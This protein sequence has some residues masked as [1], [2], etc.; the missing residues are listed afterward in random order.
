M[1][2]L[3]FPAE[4]TEENRFA[5]AFSDHGDDLLATIRVI[6]I[7]QHGHITFAP[8]GVGNRLLLLQE[9][10]L[11][12]TKLYHQPQ[13]RSDN[14]FARENQHTC[15]RTN[16]PKGRA[17]KD[18]CR[19]GNL[20]TCRAP[21]WRSTGAVD[22]VGEQMSTEAGSPWCSV[23]NPN[24]QALVNSVSESLMKELQSALREQLRQPGTPV[25]ELN[26]LL[27]RVAREA[28]ENNIL[29]EELL[30][31]FKQ[32]WNSLPEPTRPRT[33]DQFERIRQTL[34]TLCIKAYYAE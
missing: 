2:Q 31:T 19:A 4:R 21:G 15:Q 11:H 1:R 6:V 33:A 30:V 9:F 17:W 14:F 10:R 26:A 29:P 34:V 22:I 23:D 18:P 20:W 7:D 24:S 3:G 28:R 5:S 16:R 8:H 25:P 27:K 32:L 13:Q 12:S